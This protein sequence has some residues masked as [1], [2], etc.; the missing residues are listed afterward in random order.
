[1]NGCVENNRLPTSLMGRGGRG[2]GAG[3]PK[4]TGKYG[5]KTTPIRIP[6]DTAHLISEI[7]TYN[8]ADLEKALLFL[9]C[10]KLHTD[11]SEQPMVKSDV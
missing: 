6:A 11:P 8:L 7:A 4:G 1:M 10:H 3:R 5:A 2:T 9:K